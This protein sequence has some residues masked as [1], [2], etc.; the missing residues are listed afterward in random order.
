MIRAP[1]KRKSTTLSTTK[2]GLKIDRSTSLPPPS[3]GGSSSVNSLDLNDCDNVYAEIDINT[4]LASSTNT[5]NTIAIAIVVDTA[6]T[7]TNN[8]IQSN[9]FDSF[10]S[11]NILDCDWGHLNASHM[12]LFNS[13]GDHNQG[14]DDGKR[15]KANAAT[16]D[17]EVHE[18]DFVQDEVEIR[19]KN[20]G[21]EVGSI[22]NSRLIDAID[23]G[24]YKVPKKI[25][26][27]YANQEMADHLKLEVAQHLYDIDVNDPNRS[28]GAIKKSD[29]KPIDG[30]EGK[31]LPTPFHLASRSVNTLLTTIRDRMMKTTNNTME[32]FEPIGE[33]DT[34]SAD[35]DTTKSPVHTTASVSGDDGKFNDMNLKNR[36]KQKLKLGFRFAAAV[37]KSKICQRCLLPPRPSPAKNVVNR[38]NREIGTMHD[39][40]EAVVD[41]TQYY[42]CTCDVDFGDDG[43]RGK[44]HYSDLIGVSIP[45]HFRAH[46]LSLG[47]YIVRTHIFSYTHECIVMCMYISIWTMQVIFQTTKATRKK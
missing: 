11:L 33:L 19:N 14:N 44:D 12:N 22:A 26:A 35:A 45:F 39:A 38:A 5:N 23:N 27:S 16:G 21:M 30:G 7:D 42:Y 18:Q 3:S 37:K 1:F 8:D 6:D 46:F 17:E 10:P 20:I 2:D 4:A 32:I 29:C 41:S 28:T 9:V 34:T 25:I 36:F 31:K 24:T 15:A 40:A 43:T 13:D 47:R